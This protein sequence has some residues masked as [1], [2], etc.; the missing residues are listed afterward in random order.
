MEISCDFVKRD[1]VTQMEFVV[2]FYGDNPKR[3][4]YSRDEHFTHTPWRQDNHTMTLVVDNPPTL[5]PQIPEPRTIPP[6]PPHTHTYTPHYTQS[7]QGIPG[8]LVVN[9]KSEIT[10]QTH[11]PLLFMAGEKVPP[12]ITDISYK[13]HQLFSSNI[14][15]TC[16]Q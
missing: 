9:G 11:R 1:G 12:H 2:F 15:M 6:P 16:Q 10:P 7:T 14:M 4:R 8:R 3:Q 5:T 13:Q